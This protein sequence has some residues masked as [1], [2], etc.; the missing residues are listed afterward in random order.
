MNDAPSEKRKTGGSFPTLKSIPKTSFECRE[1]GVFADRE[2][3]CQVWHMCQ[4]VRKHS[5][6]CPNG[7]IFS[8]KAGVCDWW[9][10]LDCPSASFLTLKEYASPSESRITETVARGRRGRQP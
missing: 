5:F 2:A 1:T 3:N 7:T 6:L 8:E 9:Y 4:G 10:N